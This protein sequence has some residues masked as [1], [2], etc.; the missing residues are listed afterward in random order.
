MP[1]SPPRAAWKTWPT[2][3]NLHQTHMHLRLVRPHTHT[4]STLPPFLTHTN[5]SRLVF[6]KIC[7]HAHPIKQGYRH[8]YKSSHDYQVWSALIP[9]SSPS[10]LPA[11]RQ[12]LLSPAFSANHM[13][14]G[15]DLQGFIFF[16]C[17]LTVECIYWLRRGRIKRPLQT[18]PKQ[19]FKPQPAFMIFFCSF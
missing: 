16:L 13:L 10:S 14:K 8:A 18:F 15:K 1:S 3:L 11:E 6:T 7:S 4:P 5:T 17:T 2:A 12:D 9:P 19:G